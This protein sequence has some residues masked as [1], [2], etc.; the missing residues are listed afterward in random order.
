MGTFRWASAFLTLGSQ[1]QSFLGAPWIRPSLRMVPSLSRRAMALRYLS[2]SPHYFFRTEANA[3]LRSK[4]FLQS[5]CERNA[6]SRAVIIDKIVVKYVL[7]EF[8]VLDYGC[9]PGF[10]AAAVSKRVAKVLACDIA[11]GVLACAEILNAAPN[12]EYRIIPESGTIPVKDASVNL[13]YSF[14]V[15]QHVTDEVFVK[16]LREWR[17]I[18]KPNGKVVCHVL[19]DDPEWKSEKEWRDDNSLKGK[20]K[21]RIALHCFKRK[22]RDVE[23]RFDAAGFA[24]L[25]IIPVADFNLALED[26]ICKQH[27]CVAY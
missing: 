26:D 25:G 18:L 1:F 16:I 24:V 15:V 10:L 2:M 8:T 21:W 3:H 27:V 5:E 22:R 12:I 6:Q 19:L 13:I 9:G 14:A 20:L 23:E 7:P 4:A 17:R 11:D